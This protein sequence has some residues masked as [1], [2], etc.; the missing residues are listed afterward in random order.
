MTSQSRVDLPEAQRRRAVETLDRV[1]AN[2]IDLHYQVKQAHWTVK[3]PQFYARHLL[4][5]QLADRL[6]EY[7]DTLAE[8]AVILGGV[9]QGTVRAAAQNTT[10]ADYDLQLVDGMHHVR[11]L[12]QRYEQHARSLRHAIEEVH[13]DAR[14]PATEDLLT[15]QLRGIE[16]DMWFLDSHLQT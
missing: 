14:D 5:D 2:S 11:A 12:G 6:R 13:R 4:F 9:P 7:T 3:G 15:Q 16:M 1:L 10:L 8:R